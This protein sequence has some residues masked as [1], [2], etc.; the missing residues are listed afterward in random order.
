MTIA[1]MIPSLGDAELS[2]LLANA[3]RLTTGAGSARA[4]AEALIP[5]IEAEQATRAAKAPPPVRK[6]RAPARRKVAA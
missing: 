5:M 3:Q 6:P 2:N 4:K 1:D